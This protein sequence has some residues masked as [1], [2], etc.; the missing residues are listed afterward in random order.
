MLPQEIIRKKRDGQ[1]LT[2]EAIAFVVRGIT[3][4]SLS[5]SQV[6]AFAMAVFFRNMTPRE[7]T[8]MT[9]GLARSGRTLDWDDLDLPGPVIDKHSTGGVGDKVSLMLAPIVAACGGFVPMISGRGL[10][11]TGGTLDK[12]ASISGYDVRPDIAT[13]RRVVREVGCAVIGQTDDLAP[14]DRR[15][16]GVRD[17]TGTVESIPLIVSSILSKKIAAG[18]DG[19]VMDV[20]CGSGAFCDSEAMA[21]E[22]AHTLVS[23]ANDAGLSTTA[24]ITDMDRVLGREVGNALE[25]MEAVAYL[26]GEGARDPRLHEVVMALAGEMLA[27]GDLAPSVAAGRA[28]AEAALKDGRAAEKFAR[29]VSALGGPDDFLERPKRYLEQARIVRPCTAGRP[30]LVIGMNAREVGLAVVALGGGR[31]HADDAIDPSVGLSGM[32]DIGAEVQIGSPLCLVHAASEA[33]AETAAD[34]VRRAIRIGGPA[35]RPGPVVIDRIVV[36]E[37]AG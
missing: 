25:V 23:V 14:A 8:A 27:L 4:G 15:L 21:R 7:L 2:E 13:F 31:T 28:R 12:L 11:H 29:M 34:Q 30:G 5:E 32:I 6:A 19:L 37:R 1:E 36:E 22:L 26:K 3:D 10:G 17:V 33:A 18:L 35:P 9:L 24:L 20:K 16:Y